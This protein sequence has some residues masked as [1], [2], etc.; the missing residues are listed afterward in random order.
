MSMK[1]DFH[2]KEHIKPNIIKDMALLHNDKGGNFQ[3]Q[4]GMLNEESMRH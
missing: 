3:E 4:I 2:Y 1:A